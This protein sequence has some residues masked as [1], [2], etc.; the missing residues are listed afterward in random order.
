MK[1]NTV[2]AAILSLSVTQFAFGTTSQVQGPVIETCTYGE[3]EAQVTI[4]IHKEVKKGAKKTIDLTH[5]TTFKRV[6]MPIIPTPAAPPSDKAYSSYNASGDKCI[7]N[8]S[9]GSEM[10]GSMNYDDNGVVFQTNDLKCKSR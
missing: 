8:M 3:G 1:K 2:V 6:A 9:Y 10:Q 5:G 7:L 4:T